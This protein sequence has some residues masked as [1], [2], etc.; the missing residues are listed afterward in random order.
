MTLHQRDHMAVARPSKQVTFPMPGNGTILH[1]RRSFAN[2]NG[3]DDLSLGMPMNAGV[4]RTADAAP[5][6]K[7]LNQLYFERSTRL[8]E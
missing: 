3:I 6:A 1:F 5:G 4:L 8:Y 7:V 2:G